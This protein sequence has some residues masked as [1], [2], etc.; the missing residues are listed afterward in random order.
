[1]KILAIEHEMPQ[2]TPT[3]FA[4]H[5]RAEAAHVWE[6]YQQGIIRE[7]YFRA[8]RNEAILMLECDD[9]E[10]AGKLLA[11]LPLVQHGLINFELMPLRP[12]PGFARLFDAP[13]PGTTAQ[14]SNR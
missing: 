1:M 10:A 14:A 8:D 13:S 9:V 12:Y 7:P 5:V 6:L 3:Q 2:A 4:E 11:T